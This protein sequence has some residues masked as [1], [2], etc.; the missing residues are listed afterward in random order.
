LSRASTQASP[1]VFLN[2]FF[3]KLAANQALDCKQS[4]AGISHRLPL[5]RCTDQNFTVILIRNDGRRGARTFCV[6]DHLGLIAL[7]DRH[8]GIGG[9]EV[10]T[11][12]FTH[13]E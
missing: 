13:D 12:D 10:D 4:V 2:F 1:Y 8:A 3:F 6:L 7:H 9:P 11:D 5:G